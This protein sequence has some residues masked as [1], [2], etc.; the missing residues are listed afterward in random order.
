MKNIQNLTIDINKKPF[1][2]ITANKGEVGSRFIKINIVDN[3][4][5]V[6]LTGVTI[7]LYAKKP[8]GKKV[9]NSVTIEDKTNGVVLA[10]LTSQILSVVG[11]VRLTLL[12]VKDGSK[13]ASKQFLVNVDESIV[14]DEAIESTNEFTALVDAL[15][16]VNNIDSRFEEVDSQL[17]HK[18]NKN[19][20]W[21]MANM[22][23]D[24]KEAMTGGS[25][26]VVGVDSVLNENIVDRQI[27]YNKTDFIEV[28]INTFN[29]NTIS[30][31]GWWVSI[32]NGLPESNEYTTTLH[33]SN[34][35]PVMEDDKYTPNHNL[36]SYCFYNSK[37]EF[38]SGSRTTGTITIPKKARYI[39]LNVYDK[40]I[41]TLQFQKGTEV[42]GL[43]P[44]ELIIKDL[45]ISRKFNESEGNINEIPNI[46]KKV[47]MIERSLNKSFNTNKNVEGSEFKP[48]TGWNYSSSI[49][50]GWSSC[51][52]TPSNF[53]AITFKVRSRNVNITSIKLYLQEDSVD[54]KILLE[55]T[56]KV[57]IEP[58]TIVDITWDL[59]SVVYN[60]DRKYI[61][62]TYQC[63]QLSDLYQ[64]GMIKEPYPASRYSVEGN[65]QHPSNMSKVV[66]SESYGGPVI[67]TKV[68]LRDS[69]YTIPSDKARALIDEFISVKGFENS[70]NL[71]DEFIAEGSN[72]LIGEES[73]NSSTFSGWGGHI[74][75][76]KEIKELKFSVRNRD[77]VPTTIIK[78]YITDFNKDGT[79][80][81]RGVLDVNIPIGERQDI[82]W[83]LDDPLINTEGKNLYFTYMCDTKITKVSTNLNGEGN[84]ITHGWPS[85]ITN[86]NINLEPTQATK[87]YGES[88]GGR[89]TIWCQ[90]GHASK[91]YEPTQTFIDGIGKAISESCRIVLPDTITAVVGDNLQLFYRGLIEA[92]NPYIYDIRIRCLRGKA[93]PRYFEFKP[94]S[95]DVGVYDFGIEVYNNE[96]MLITKA[97]C[98]LK[99]VQVG[100]S[101]TTKKK[102]LC[103]GDSLTSGGYWCSEAMRRLVGSGGTPTAHNRSNIEFIGTKKDSSGCKWEGYGGWT[104]DSY[105][106]KPDAT[107]SDIWIYCT[108]DKTSSDQHSIW[109]DSNGSKWSLETIETNK[110]KFTRYQAHTNLAPTSP[111]VLTH[112]QNAV[113]TS[114]INFT[115]CKVADGNPFWDMTTNRVNFKQYCQ[116]NGFEGIDYVYILLTW[117]GG[118]VDKW[119]SESNSAFVSSA[120]KFIDI[121]H[122]D[123]PEAK[124]RIMGVQLPS[125]NGGT[126]ANYGA[127]GGYADTYGLVRGVF[128]L[129]IAYQEL[130]NDPNYIDYVEFINVSGQFDSE[131]NMPYTLAPVN[132]RSTVT[133]MKGTN[134]VH[135]S[136]EGYLQI[137][138][139]AYRSLVKDLLI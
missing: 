28:G 66:G 133:E 49:F 88:T 107:K 113:N 39:R 69:D 65:M 109:I 131:Y 87:V 115:D 128:G 97:K 96:S 77:V 19:H 111:G 73:Y 15:G 23:Q 63:D 117:N 100:S 70:F 36:H 136:P 20:V 18:V 57:N 16:R 139:V 102:I 132:N 9:F 118:R 101:P 58:N 123:Y 120:K 45:D 61:Q 22:G 51:I 56:L 30:N 29:K 94:T 67:W 80:L 134:G 138:D 10:E 40:D 121:L 108:H 104:W 105:L 71:V 91:R 130:A 3:S 89:N 50:S 116:S 43:Y 11:I 92:V 34:Y 27:S 81:A 72:G 24:I 55:E 47:N 46:N 82:V 86:G 12:L 2:T 6:D 42:V 79:I 52:G 126:G 137:G 26:A 106:S 75:T 53:D 35:I 84:D 122:Q 114:N 125:L 76:F 112:V 62:F 41:D 83:K 33:Y 78:C 25:V 5:P 135:P 8:D 90:V 95:D 17:E 44:Y 85:Y 21:N 64:A 68:G 110:L 32:A 119:N 13:L 124:V 7:S 4:T 60:K 129:N 103:V 59:P 31:I 93:Y 74:G 98:K 48:T 14:D 37:K 54:G 1:Q 38:I 99:V 127:N